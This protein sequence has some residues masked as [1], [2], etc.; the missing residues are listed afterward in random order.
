MSNSAPDR[1]HDPILDVIAEFS[2]VFTF[3]RTRWTGYTE[4]LHPDLSGGSIFVLQTILRKGPI[5]ATEISHRLRMDKALISRQVA[6]LRKLELV[7]AQPASEDRRVMLLT[8][9]DLARTRLDEVRAKMADEYRQRF[10][11]WDPAEI[12][13][14]FEML[15]RFNRGSDGFASPDSPAARCTP[16]HE[17]KTD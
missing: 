17:S 1:P 9:T 7:D 2:E 3:I 5:T 15:H 16:P 12:E 10:D 6:L 8:G 14:L 4:Q 11:S 13:T